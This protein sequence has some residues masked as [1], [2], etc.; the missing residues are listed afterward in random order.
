MG[1]GAPLASTFC[2]FLR[3]QLLSPQA[4]RLYVAVCLVVSLSAC[5]SSSSKFNSSSPATD[6]R[7]SI[8]PQA[9]PQIDIVS[10]NDEE[11]AE[12]KSTP[13][14]FEVLF[15]EATYAW[16]RAQLFFSSY[17]GGGEHQR[18]Q[19][20]PGVTGFSLSNAKITHHQFVY[21]VIKSR[22]ST[23][24]HFLVRCNPRTQQQSPS[25][26]ASRLRAQNLA[27]FIRSGKLDLG[28]VSEK[29][30]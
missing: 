6:L 30:S 29:N 28:L 12:I 24:E 26:R 7:A 10:S 18:I 22:G 15:P 1:A 20:A 21:E 17:L 8:S 25:A 5:S 13:L 11:L 3:F 27:R 23:G 16:E 14:S 2:N 4:A 9:V 19:S